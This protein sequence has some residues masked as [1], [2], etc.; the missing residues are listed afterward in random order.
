MGCPAHPG[1]IAIGLPSLWDIANNLL[2]EYRNGG[3]PSGGIRASAER[4]GT[5]FFLNDIYRGQKIIIVFD[6]ASI[7]QQI[8]LLSALLQS[9]QEMFEQAKS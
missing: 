8:P 7:I 4:P 9:R 6:A 1:G 2:K 3:G 5:L